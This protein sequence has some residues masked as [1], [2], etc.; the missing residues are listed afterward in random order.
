M[1]VS[2]PPGLHVYVLCVYALSPSFPTHLPSAR[3]LAHSQVSSVREYATVQRRHSRSNVLQQ[4]IRRDTKVQETMHKLRGQTMGTVESIH[5]YEANMFGKYRQHYVDSQNYI[6]IRANYMFSNLWRERGLYGEEIEQDAYWK[7]DVIEGPARVRRRLCRNYD[8]VETYA[9]LLTDGSSALQSQQN[10]RA[11]ATATATPD[12]CET[13]TQKEQ[14]V[15]SE[16]SELSDFKVF[17]ADTLMRT[18]AEAE[19]EGRESIEVTG[20]AEEKGTEED[21][22]TDSKDGNAPADTAEDEAIGSESDD[23]TDE[24]FKEED[25]TIMRQLEPGDAIQ[26][27]F[28]CSRIQ[29]LDAVDSVLLLCKRNI[30]IIDGY[31]YVYDA[32]TQK[33]TIM[34]M[35]AAVLELGDNYR[36]IVPKLA[37]N[38]GAT[39]PEATRE[40][41]TEMGDDSGIIKCPY[42][43][44]Q[45][46]HKRRFLLREVAVEIF[47]DDG[48]DHLL[49]F[50]KSDRDN[51]YKKL[52][53]S[54]VGSFSKS[55]SK[56]IMDVAGQTLVSAGF[57]DI[58]E[59]SKGVFSQ[60]WG[61]R[62]PTQRWVAG[63]LSNF[64]YLMWINT[65]AGRSYND[66]T[67]YP[68]FPWI[69]ADYDS[70]TLDLNDPKTFRDLSKPMGNQT[71]ERAQYYT[72]RY[73]NWEDPTGET[74]PFHYGTH[75]SSAMI[76][77]SYLIRMEPYTQMFLT[78]QGGHFDHP[79]RMFHSIKEAWES[80]SRHN[81][82]D[83]KELI[84]EFFYLPEFLVNSNKFGYVLRVRL[85]NF[86]WAA[87]CVCCISPACSST[88][89]S[90]RWI[91]IDLG[92]F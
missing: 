85:P 72:Q 45:E 35:A 74:P 22:Q 77:A 58:A 2:F 46:V 61:E 3:L 17:S 57:R 52:I 71:P 15:I 81:T 26:F 91:Q 60:L 14:E 47:S 56:G 53:H 73:N 90:F 33:S 55:I 31:R 30:Y 24:D 10:T 37:D 82:A 65:W 49:A 42:K 8:F 29:G 50:V 6:S 11:Q 67:Q 7:L 20:E 41:K 54:T 92:V 18:G 13:L 34:E 79:D 78:L 84:P 32:A 51:V 87:M 40:V 68:V 28:N 5:V 21:P 75:F 27:C 76:V 12:P 44:V 64:Q 25:M 88:Q 38:F 39:D 19:S 59:E 1:C 16:L 9:G 80:A 86:F 89:P 62:S 69:L 70:E 36:P 48:R 63:E 83:V 43:C 66:L 4:H 23:D